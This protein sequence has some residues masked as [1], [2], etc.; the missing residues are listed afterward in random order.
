MLMYDALGVLNN[1][2]GF[3]HNQLFNYLIWTSTLEDSV[4]KTKEKVGD[5][6]IKDREVEGRS[7]MFGLKDKEDMKKPFSFR[8]GQRPPIEFRLAFLKNVMEVLKY[9]SEWEQEGF[10]V[11]G[12]VVTQR[13]D[14]VK[15]G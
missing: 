11:F 14:G 13:K 9:R 3:G 12:V 4:L 8:V 6:P 10:S 7:I 2:A 15:N 1:K 5:E